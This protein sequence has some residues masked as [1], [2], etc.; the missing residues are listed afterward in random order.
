MLSFE[1]HSVEVVSAVMMMQDIVPN[2]APPVKPSSNEV[3]PPTVR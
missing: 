2:K 3:P 1:P